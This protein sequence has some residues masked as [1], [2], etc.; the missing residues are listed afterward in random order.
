L[1]STVLFAALVGVIPATA[2]A[3]DECN[4]D[5]CVPLVFRRLADVSPT[6]RAGGLE[7]VPPAAYTRA[8]TPEHFTGLIVQGTSDCPAAARD[9][10]GTWVVTQPFTSPALG[11]LRRICRYEWLPLVPGTPA[12]A[13]L[14]PDL[15]AGS[16]QV[17]RLEMDVA[18]TSPQGSS[19]EAPLDTWSYLAENYGEQ[20]DLH[21]VSGEGPAERVRVAVVDSA[22]FRDLLPVPNTSRSRHNEGVGSVIRALG[23]GGANSL[24]P[25]PADSLSCPAYLVEV[26]DYLALPRL[27][28]DTMMISDPV[29][30]GYFG[31][32][33]DVAVAVGQALKDWLEPV[34]G[35]AYSALVIN[36]SV[37]WDAAYSPLRP[38][39]QRVAARTAFEAIRIAGCQGA[40]VV[41]SA[42]NHGGSGHTGPLFPAGWERLARTC[43]AD[44]PA[45]ALVGTYDPMVHAVGAV[46]GAD[47]TLAVSRPAG[48]PR[49]V[50]PAAHV[51]VRNVA[52]SQCPPGALGFCWTMPPPDA[53]TEV[54]TGTS[55]AAAAVSGM[56]GFIWALR[57]DLQAGEVMEVIYRTG[58][59]LGTPAKF[60]L[61]TLQPMHRLDACSAVQV[62]CAG[63]GGLCAS[64]N[65]AECAS[66]RA[67]GEPI[68]PDVDYL[69]S[70]AYPEAANLPDSTATKTCSTSNPCTAPASLPPDFTVEPFAHPQPG[71]TN[72]PLCMLRRGVD[73]VW[74]ANGK[75]V[76]LGITE[77]LTGGYFEL[78][79]S[80]G[81]LKRFPVSAQVLSFTTFNQV[82]SLAAGSVP[83]KGRIVIE[84]KTAQYVSK[85][86]LIISY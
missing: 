54:L 68:V 62:A 34:D 59:D 3:L 31:T 30:G 82:L 73:G 74:R 22:P 13:R 38:T 20:L 14:L 40:L 26:G 35:V 76:N 1:K 52:V 39:A 60:G 9:A 28:R 25:D 32:Q 37:G 8:S 10:D 18:A 45:P 70:T 29:L 47:Q 61:G 23:C 56:A 7:L 11:E 69:V 33:T 50:A 5:R 44:S 15:R 21:E 63:Q 48:I 86:E 51:A 64:L 78:T 71:A 58:A 42:G 79:L 6:V 24:L 65:I 16:P 46:N 67:A 41:A 85:D 2:Q 53:G 55:V 19:V 84:S 81:A 72:C 49:L 12:N 36:M 57:P 80:T 27:F 77:P 17:M 66:V 4:V 43:P 75:L 83:V